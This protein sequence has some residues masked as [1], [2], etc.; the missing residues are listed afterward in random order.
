[1]D[2]RDIYMRT[3]S[4]RGRKREKEI[5]AKGMRDK[6]RERGGA[7][8]EKE[9]KQISNCS[10]SARARTR[11]RTHTTKSFGGRPQQPPLRIRAGKLILA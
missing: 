2:R 8:R 3:P 10:I 9:M 7:G 5:I 1:M 11:E 4:T 6:E